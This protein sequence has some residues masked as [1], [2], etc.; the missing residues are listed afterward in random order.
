MPALL[1]SM[2]SKAQAFLLEPQ[3]AAESPSLEGGKRDA[4][5]PAPASVEVVVVG[6]SPGSGA[7][8]VASGLAACLAGRGRSSHALPTGEQDGASVQDGSTAD[9]LR[10]AL[11]RL[12]GGPVALVWDAGCARSSSYREQAL[13]ADAVVLVAPPT[14]EPALAELVARTLAKR[15]GPILL[16]AN[17]V[18]ARERWAVRAAVCIPDSRIGAALARRG[19]RPGGPV[20]AAFG[21]LAS[22]VD[23]RNRA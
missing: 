8:T 11:S 16:V 3:V 21:E 4:A 19:R 15:L 13:R 5:T 9:G 18:R 20:G 12:A 17:R 6:L 7:S 1:S 14:A 10:V 23:P 22:I 2:L